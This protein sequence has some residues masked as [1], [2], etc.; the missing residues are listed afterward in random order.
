MLVVLSIL[1]FAF[2]PACW[3]DFGA[4]GIPLPED[5]EEVFDI[6]T[7]GAYDVSMCTA[8]ISAQCIF[9]IQIF[10]GNCSLVR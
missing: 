4:A 6:F 8:A 2:F 3:F 5:A 1:F 7:Y 10:F 9:S